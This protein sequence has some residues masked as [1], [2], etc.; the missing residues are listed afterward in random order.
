MGRRRNR[1]GFGL[2][3]VNSTKNVVN[4]T[5]S[6]T[7]ATSVKQIVIAKDSALLTQSTDVER[8][9]TIKAIWVELDV[10]GTGTSGTNNHFT[11]YLIKNPGNNLTNP[12]PQS[13]GSSNE[14]KFVFR[15]FSQMVMLTS[16]GAPNFRFAGW[17]RIP[18]HYQRFGADDRIEFVTTTQPAGLTGHV[19]Y[20]MIY[21]WYK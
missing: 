16:D 9:C 4:D 3:P 18:K 5:Y 14:K 15:M 17:V 12:A 13:V 11:G 7:S 20:N 2:R 19:T 10:C 21:K 6:I 1:T 8:S